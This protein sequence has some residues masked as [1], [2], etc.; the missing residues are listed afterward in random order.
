MTA[1]LATVFRRR[2]FAF[3]R[4]GFPP[5]ATELRMLYNSCC[6]VKV[7]SRASLQKFW[8]LSNNIGSKILFFVLGIIQGLVANV[9]RS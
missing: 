3:E 4:L 1:F 7:V 8:G 5:L 6:D 2:G 9:I